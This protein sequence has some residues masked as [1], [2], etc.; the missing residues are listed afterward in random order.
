MGR[1]KKIVNLIAIGLMLTLLGCDTQSTPTTAPVAETPALAPATIASSSPSAQQSSSTDA[2]EPLS[3]QQLAD[4]L[5]WSNQKYQEIC[6]RFDSLQPNTYMYADPGWSQFA[7]DNL[8]LITQKEESFPEDTSPNANGKMLRWVIQGD[9]RGA[10]DV[11][12]QTLSSMN[13][14]LGTGGSNA[15]ITENQTFY[16]KFYKKTPR[17]IKNWSF[18]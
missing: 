6:S 14:Y 10:V 11:V 2:A 12:W 7:R 5:S 1:M 18:N 16:Q 15:D 9:V 13:E 8:A 3:N 17:R 4:L